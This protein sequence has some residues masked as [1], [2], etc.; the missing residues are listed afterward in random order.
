MMFDMNKSELNFK[1]LVVFVWW[2]INEKVKICRLIWNFRLKIV[3]KIE[4]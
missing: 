2:N 4:F 3:L 1:C